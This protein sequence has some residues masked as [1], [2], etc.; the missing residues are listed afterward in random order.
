M[1]GIILRHRRYD[2]GAGEVWAGR[3]EQLG[4]DVTVRYVRLPADP[5]VRAEALGEIRRQLDVRHPH[6]V[7]VTD[8]IRTADGLAVVAEPVPETVSLSRLLAARGR[9]EPGEVVTIGLPVAQALAAAHGAGLV[10]GELTALDI[11]LEPNGRP[12][13]AGVGVAALTS[14]GGSSADDVH[15]LAELLLGAMS[16]AT[17]P[18]AAAVAVAVAMALID[19]PLRR[20]SAAELA[21]GLARSATPLPIRMTGVSPGGS[22]GSEIELAS[23]PWIDEAEPAAD[24]GDDLDDDRDPW[25]TGPEW[26][27]GH[28][29]TARAQGGDGEVAGGD[30]AGGRL[31]PPPGGD[32]SEAAVPDVWAGGGADAA[33][34]EPGEPASPP[35]EGIAAG[36]AAGESAGTPPGPGPG[37]GAGA[38]SGRTQPRDGRTAPSDPSELVGSLH[39]VGRDRRGGKAVRRG[40][41]SA[42]PAPSAAR[43][44]G[45]ASGRVRGGARGG[46]AGRSGR[47][48]RGGR[49]RLL[50]PAIGCVGLVAVVIAVV[51]MNGGSDRAETRGAPAAGGGGGQDPSATPVNGRSPEQA[52]RA[53]LE[54]LNVARSR[55][56]ERADLTAL[57]AAD[58]PDSAALRTDQATVR[59]LLEKGAHS[60]PVRIQ[61]I[62]LEIQLERADQV[63]LRVTE[64]VEAYNFLNAAGA[65]LASEPGSPE[66]IKILTLW[67][68]SG[69][70][71]LAGSESV[72]PG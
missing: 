56:F 29:H 51:L 31:L 21:A 13:L 64:S 53:V 5:L 15:D 43:R 32:P 37:V 52:W 26:Q 63:V 2:A 67:R 42:T 71:R 20:P 6:L 22:V 61:I 57:D 25:A 65:V 27:A 40:G 1:P 33:W 4:A 34:Q 38:A 45:R 41:R 30:G 54:E 19:D 24:A 35:S 62:D 66:S 46:P 12:V 59:T 8:A 50:L 18:D 69:G 16:Q 23:D 39:P 7:S 3:V 68:T 28:R 55:A 11:L 47:S 70:W 14:P 17:G 48:G 60:S 36:T 10:H 72:A 49:N 58:A 44:A 9:L